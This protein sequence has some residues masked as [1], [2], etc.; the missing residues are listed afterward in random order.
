ME[1]KDIL[2]CPQ[3]LG[4][5]ELLRKLWVLLCCKMYVHNIFPSSNCR[6]EKI[7]LTYR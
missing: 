3:D 7:A 5:L 6:D 1:P 4:I 2:P